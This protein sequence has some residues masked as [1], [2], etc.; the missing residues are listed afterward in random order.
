MISWGECEKAG[1][2]ISILQD[3]SEPL[4]NVSCSIS[5][6]DPRKPLS[7]KQ[8]LEM[9]QEARPARKEQT[10]LCGPLTLV[11]QHS[12]AT[13]PRLPHAQDTGFWGPGHGVLGPRLRDFGAQ[14]SEHLPLSS[15]CYSRHYFITPWIYSK[16]KVQYQ[17]LNGRWVRISHLFLTG[18][19]IWG[20]FWISLGILYSSF[21]WARNGASPVSIIRPLI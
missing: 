3:F 19:E 12:Q 13:A 1:V 14:V 15:G 10:E 4:Q 9:H 7:S 6:A 18:W 11:P 21:W 8:S 16:W 20:R 5:P 2:E 17:T